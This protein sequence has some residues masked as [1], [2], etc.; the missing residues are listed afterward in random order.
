[1][2]AAEALEPGAT[3][4]IWADKS[5]GSK[6]EGLAFAFLAEDAD[7]VEAHEELAEAVALL[8]ERPALE[9]AIRAATALFASDP[10]GAWA[11]QQ[12]LRKR[13]LEFESRLGQMASRRAGKPTRN[14][15]TPSAGQ[16][17]QQELD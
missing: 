4:P 8:I 6:R 14:R 7:P 13:K 10:E 2:E 12:R 17:D 5:E 9:E 15:V 11:E 3:A 1:M 16:A